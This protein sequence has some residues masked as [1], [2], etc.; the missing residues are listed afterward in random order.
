MKTK[1]AAPGE[2]IMLFGT[3]FG[4]TTPASASGELVGQPGRI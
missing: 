4:P 3:G 2:T 1:P